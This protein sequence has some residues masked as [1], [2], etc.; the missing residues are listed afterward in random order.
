MTM[1]LLF[2]A[3]FAHIGILFLLVAPQC[4]QFLD[5]D[6]D[7][8][9]P[10]IRDQLQSVSS[11]FTPLFYN[12]VSICILLSLICMITVVSVVS[13]SPNERE[14]SQPDG[15]NRMNNMQV[16]KQRQKNGKDQ[17]SDNK[18]PKGP[19]QRKSRRYRS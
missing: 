11:R 14:S 9:V 1:K 2:I 10:L 5:M 3:Y 8:A 18:G 13:L 4:A 12:I 17:I 16:W 7:T 15:Y 19:A 6:P